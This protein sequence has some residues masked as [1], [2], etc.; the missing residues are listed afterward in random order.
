LVAIYAF[1]Y[2]GERDDLGRFAATL[3]VFGAAM[4]G[5]V[6]SDNLLALFVFWELTSISSY[7]LIGFD[8]RTEAARNAALQALLVTGAGG[9]ALLAGFV[10]I[11][12]DAG[13][14]SLSALSAAPPTGA[15]IPA[16]AV[17][18]LIGACTK[19][20]QVPFHGWL[21]AAMAAPTPVSAY[22]HSATM[23][24]AGVFAVAVLTPVLG[25]AG[26]W[27]PLTVGVGTVTMVWG[28]YQSLR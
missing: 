28:S 7:A 17:L 22:L 25:D 27:V 24:K 8:N 1:G 13:T 6:W 4:C 10:L 19:S 14:Y 11:G 20:A 23:V 9:L 2:F 3:L 16:A 5:V 15:T 18:V 12:I 21:S 26:P